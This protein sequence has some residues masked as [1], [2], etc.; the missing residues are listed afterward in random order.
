L[1][2]G[3]QIGARMAFKERYERELAEARSQRRPVRWTMSAGYDIGH[4]LTT[5]SVAV[6]ENRMSLENALNFVPTER[7]SDFAQMLPPSAAK[8]LL[9]GKVEKLPDLPE[10]AGVLAKMR[11]EGIVPEEMNT[12]PRPPRRAPSDRSPEEAREL[13]EKVNA[14]IELLKRSRS[15]SGGGAA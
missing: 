13:R 9:S 14:Q 10:L 3:D 15:G 2:D 11:M 5:L 8:G 4:R 7:R 1:L 12:D 6:Q